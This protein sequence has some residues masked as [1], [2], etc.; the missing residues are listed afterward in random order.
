MSPRRSRSRDGPGSLAKAADDAGH[1]ASLG[2]DQAVAERVELGRGDEGVAETRVDRVRSAHGLA[3]EAQIDAGFAG[4]VR[5]QPGAADVGDEADAGLRH[6]EL[7]TLGDDAVARVTREPDAAAHDDAV[8]DRHVG[9]RV[10]ADQGVEPVL[11][12][13]EA[14]CISRALLPAVVERA[15]VAA[16]AQ[17]PVAGA[18]QQDQRDGGIVLP[19]QQRRPDP[20]HHGMRERVE[21]LR[22]VHGDAACPAL[23]PDQDL[24]TCRCFHGRSL[25]IPDDI[26][27][28]EPVWPVQLR[29]AAA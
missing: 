23:T 12:A 6:G 21:S 24:V 15:H 26:G 1:G 13:P 19:R 5:E 17:R 3:G 29:P 2:I 25:D 22:P 20:P 11:F 7:G 10:A 27:I 4:G 8:L 9:L 14:A 18:I 16:G 28:S